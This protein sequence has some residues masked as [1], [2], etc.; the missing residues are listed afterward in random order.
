M[1]M[2]ENEN[3]RGTEGF[4]KL[5]CVRGLK[6]ENLMRHLFLLLSVKL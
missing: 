2:S 3:A 1:G 6:D 4:R 5:V